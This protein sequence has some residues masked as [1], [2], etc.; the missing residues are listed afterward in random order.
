MDRLISGCRMPRDASH[1]MS[2]S[3]TSPF[4]HSLF[5]HLALSDALSN[6]A[7]CEQV[8]LAV[9]RHICAAIV[10]HDSACVQMGLW[11]VLCV[12]AKILVFL[13]LPSPRD[14]GGDDDK[15]EGRLQ[16][17]QETDWDL[18]PVGFSYVSHG[19]LVS[20]FT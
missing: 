3:C 8:V 19:V 1:L 14:G 4:L 10:H 20:M 6:A 13:P 9:G 12:C 15:L 18:H 5:L 11:A 17:D 16:K 7:R 2:A